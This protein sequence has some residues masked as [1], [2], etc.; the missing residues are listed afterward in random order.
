MQTL[1]KS[2]NSS[3]MKNCNFCKFVPFQNGIVVKPHTLFYD[4]LSTS[5]KYLKLYTALSFNYLH[6]N[7]LAAYHKAHHDYK[8]EL[9]M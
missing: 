8:D 5:N 9:W 1:I 6:E 3:N 2:L 4:T 7:F